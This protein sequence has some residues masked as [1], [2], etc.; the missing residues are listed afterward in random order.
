MYISSLSS[1]QSIASCCCCYVCDV[2]S[3]IYLARGVKLSRFFEG[4]QK[5]LIDSKKFKKKRSSGAFFPLFSPH[6]KAAAFVEIYQTRAL[7][8][9]S[10]KQERGEN[11]F[12]RPF[13]LSFCR[14]LV[15]FS[16][17]C[18]VVDCFFV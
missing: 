16:A 7:F 2:C 9:L 1:E 13:I 4:M 5:N 11:D 17:F 18:V 3:L 12:G 14:L 6:N 8:K 15:S 10:P